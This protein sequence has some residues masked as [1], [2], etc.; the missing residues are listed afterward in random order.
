[1]GDKL[2]DMSVLCDMC[3]LCDNAVLID[4]DKLR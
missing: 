2:R 1:M 3:A 4:I